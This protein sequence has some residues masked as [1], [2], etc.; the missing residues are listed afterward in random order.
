MFVSSCQAI[1]HSTETNEINESLPSSKLVILVSVWYS[2]NMYDNKRLL[3]K[4]TL[5]LNTHKNV[6]QLKFFV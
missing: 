6:H 4:A 5:A 1:V 2:V 3:Q